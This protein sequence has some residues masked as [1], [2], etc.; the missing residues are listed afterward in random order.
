M[1]SRPEA[2][3]F[4]VSDVHGHMPAFVSILHRHGLAES[5]EHWTK[6]GS[7]LWILGDYL[8]RGDEGL[9]VVDAVRTLQRQA[10]NLGGAVHPLLGNHELQFLAAVH[11]GD[12]EMSG[13]GETSFLANW[14][15][16]GG[17]DKEKAAVSE[18]QVQWMTALPLLAMSE[19]DLLMHSDTRAYLELGSTVAEINEAGHAI[20]TSRNSDEWAHLHWI[21]TQRG[22][23]KS[24]ESRAEV[25]SALNAHRIVHGHTPLR[26]G[27]GLSGRSAARPFSYGD[28][29]VLAIDG[30]VFED[31]GHLILAEL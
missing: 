2:A 23:F 28:G 12:R 7:E 6:Q 29:K 17:R 1:S 4:A 5:A 8:D 10:R 24:P 20:M 11:F 15:R 25:L 26:T 18:E 22:E 21:M 31:G 27:F 13:D 3:R 19:G 9:A 14:R 16:Y 30:G